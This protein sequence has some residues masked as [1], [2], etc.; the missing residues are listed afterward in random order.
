MLPE[1]FIHRFKITTVAALHRGDHI[2]AYGDPCQVE[3][4]HFDAP[5]GALHIMHRNIFTGEV[6]DMQIRTTTPF[7]CFQPER[8]DHRVLMVDS[9]GVLTDTED[10]IFA[11]ARIPVRP[12]DVICTLAAPAH[13]QSWRIHRKIE[14]IMPCGE[15][16]A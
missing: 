5:Q 7:M 11:S 9:E 12:G 4:L 6:R 8:Q 10:E 1:E 3:R 15:S 2:M 14:K 16:P 13:A